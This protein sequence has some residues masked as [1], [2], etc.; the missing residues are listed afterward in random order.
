MAIRHSTP[1][2]SSFSP[3][4]R[5]AWDADHEGDAS[6][7]M[8]TASG[9]GAQTETL[10]TTMRRFVHTAQY[11]TQG[12]FET[13]R[14]ALTGT[15]GFS[16]ID[17]KAGAAYKYNGLEVLIAQTGANNY[18]FG[19][20]GNLTQTGGN[21][22]AV[23][24]RALLSATTATDCVA[25]G[26][27]AL[28]SATNTVGNTAIGR[29]SLKSTVT[30]G[31]NTAVGDSTL[32]DNTAIG[33]VAIGYTTAAAN[34][35]GAENVFIGAGAGRTRTAGNQNV[36]IGSEA[37]S[38]PSTGGDANTAVGYAAL[39]VYA[40]SESTAIGHNSLVVATGAQNTAVGVSSGGS[41]TTGTTNTFV[42]HSSGTNASQKVD[43]VNS[44][45][46]GNG[47]FTTA[48]N[49]AV[50]G[51]S[52][53]TQT[54]L[55]GVVGGATEFQLG[56]GGTE[57]ARITSG[58]YFKS[59]SSGS[60]ASVSASYHELLGQAGDIT[61][62]V[63]NTHA[64]TP[65]GM[66]LEFSAASPDNNTQY[67]LTCNDSTTTRC[68]I[69]SDGDLQNHDNAYGAISDERLKTGI[70]DSGSQWD[71]IKN[72]R[73]RKYKFIADGEQAVEQIGVVAQEVLKVSPGLVTHDEERDE[74][75]VQYSV[76]YMK[77]VKALQEAMARIE[78][79]EADVA[80]M[81]TQR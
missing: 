48:S 45:A 30:G 76:L 32:K 68:L 46:I 53:I 47:T 50:L 75:G 18:F 61:V 13:A 72:I 80:E 43:A 64:S 73:V 33:N 6:D 7:L 2:D 74:Y 19:G 4:G 66:M 5:A 16:S 40:G 79:L 65:S 27:E 15:L 69:Y 29:M 78:K 52:S 49:Q 42:G 25:I 31:N 21:N 67:F 24:W 51:N 1:A 54:L 60:Y 39:N 58:G 8:F 11:A 63:R 3:Q 62:R 23:G 38:Q 36:I 28:N 41:I 34:V 57:Y 9:S 12:N 55:R 59:S 81:K 71:D 77:A 26:S 10:Q 17:L 44:I 20:S 37:M 35:T 56:F 70:R 22:T 14:D